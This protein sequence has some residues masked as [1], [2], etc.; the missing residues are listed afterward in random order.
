V[1][2]R[3]HIVDSANR[4]AAP[5][6]AV[7]LGAHLGGAAPNFVDVRLLDLSEDG[8]RITSD[9][10]LAEGAQALLKLPGIE[11]VG[12]SVAWIDGAEIGF[13]FHRRLHESEIESVKLQQPAPRARSYS[14]GT[15]GGRA[16]F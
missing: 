6:R 5:R 13:A 16:A 11:A 9:C 12:C 1:K 10:G 7:N 14:F 3:V 8:C 4:R 15:K 2:A